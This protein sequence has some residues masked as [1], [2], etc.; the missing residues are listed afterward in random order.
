MA[1]RIGRRRGDEERA[2]D[3]QGHMTVVEHLGELRRRIFISLGAILVGAG[4]C[5][6][7]TPQII[8]FLT[9]FYRESLDRRV[10]NELIFT[11]PA[12]AFLLRLKIAT[13]GGIVVAMPVWLFQIW[14][15]VTPG[16]NPR[17]KRYAIPFIVSAIVLFAL[18]GFVAFLTLKPALRFLL[19]IGGNDLQPLLTG[20]SYLTL[21]ALMIVAFGVSFEFPVVLVFLLLARVLTTEQLR[22]WRRWALVL[23]TLFAALITPSQDPYSLLFMAAPM[24]LFYE[25][26]IAIGRMLKR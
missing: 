26:S 12:D 10:V 5:F 8:A 17:E 22:R 15:F 1:L 3:T 13:Y 18:G 2:A 21:V 6:F 23:I 11:G 19:G 7:F 14:R 4:V 16:L 9:T 20:T 24:Y 25:A